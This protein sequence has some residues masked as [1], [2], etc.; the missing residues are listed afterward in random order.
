[1]TGASHPHLSLLLQFFCL[2]A[3]PLVSSHVLR[4]K[5]MNSASQPSLQ[6]QNNTTIGENVQNL[7]DILTADPD[8]RYQKSRMLGCYIAVDMGD[9]DPEQF[10]EFP[11]SSNIADF[12]DI[13]CFFRYGGPLAEERLN[14]FWVNNQWPLHWDRWSP[15]IHNS[16]YDDKSRPFS[17]PAALRYMSA[18]WA[19]TLLKAHGQ[20]GPYQLVMLWKTKTHPELA[21]CFLNVQI[22]DEQGGGQR[23]FFVYVRTGRV[24]ETRY[25][26]GSNHIRNPP[27]HIYVTRSILLACKNMSVGNS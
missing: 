13:R 9:H 25:C 1:M 19:D 4:A 6:T 16:H 15:P 5:A 23:S 12:R 8:I 2:F 24:E 18:E 17:W 11:L 10:H 14:K 21:W 22:T 26:D 3:I 27:K 20:L 7:V